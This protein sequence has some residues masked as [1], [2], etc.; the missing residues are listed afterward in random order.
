MAQAEQIPDVAEPER[1]KIILEIM[2][3]RFEMIQEPVRAPILGKVGDSTL[4][5][6]AECRMRSRLPPRVGMA[7]RN[8]HLKFQ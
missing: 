6:S 2:R 1:F 7:I 5:I 3:D 8:K 4:V